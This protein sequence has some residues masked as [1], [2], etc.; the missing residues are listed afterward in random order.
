[1]EIDALLG[2]YQRERRAGTFESGIR[3]GLQTIL[4][5]PDFLFRL[6]RDPALWSPMRSQVRKEVDSKG[7]VVFT[8]E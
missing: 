7:R 6:E 8:N 2:L 5:S 4:A 3:V 1:M